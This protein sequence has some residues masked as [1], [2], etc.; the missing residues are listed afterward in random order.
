MSINERIRAAVLP[1]VGV[2]EPH[3]YEGDRDTYSVF[4]YTETPLAFF[5]NE[6]EVWKCNITLL[7]VL[8]LEINSL[9]L[10]RTL[11]NAL[12]AAG[13]TAPT[14]TDVGDGTEQCWQLQFEGE[15]E[16]LANGEDLI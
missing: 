9:K 2:C 11:C 12:I 4:E 3:T 15:T 14:V 13:F 6:V 1:V 10:R 7:L 16:A 8:P 5:D